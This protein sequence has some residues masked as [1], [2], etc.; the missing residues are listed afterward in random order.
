MCVSIVI[1]QPGIERSLHL[2][3]FVLGFF[4]YFANLKQFKWEISSL[5]DKETLETTG[6]SV[7]RSRFSSRQVP[8][9]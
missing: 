7:K 4:I 5:G 2:F 1:E 6:M 3:G 8:F 9:P